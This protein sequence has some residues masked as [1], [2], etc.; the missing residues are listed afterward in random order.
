MAETRPET[1]PE[2]GP[3][4]D[5]VL[6]CRDEAAALRELLPRVPESLS[7]IVVDNGSTDGTAD[8]AR[9]LGARVVSESRPGYG[10]AVH[11]GLVAATAPY[12]VVMDGDG[13]FDPAAALALVDAVMRGDADLALGCRRPVSRA[14]QP[15]HA[16]VGNRLVLSAL[17]RRTGLR[18]RDIAPL[19][20]ARREALLNLGVEDRR[21]GYPVELLDRAARAGWR[22]H[23]IDVDYHPRTAGTRSKVSGSVR[24]SLRAAYD[25]WR[26]LS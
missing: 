3:E 18:V 16:K 14:A 26:V 2:T 20:A 25:F 22:V 9:S 21:S 1:G 4:T 23:E 7:V 24:G 8:V 17:R 15:W 13:S 12:V 11:A 10:A 6:P 5:L 19:R